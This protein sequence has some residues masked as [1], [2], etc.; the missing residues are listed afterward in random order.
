MVS[1]VPVL[2]TKLSGLS[3]AFRAHL[4]MMGDQPEDMR[5]AIESVSQKSIEELS[6]KATDAYRFIA[7]NKT[8]RNQIDRFCDFIS[9]LIT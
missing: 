1:G 8:W 9:D 7:D 2:S 3:E 4:Y 6:S 5:D